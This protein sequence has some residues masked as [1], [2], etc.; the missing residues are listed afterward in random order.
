MEQDS[1]TGARRWF[2]RAIFPVS[3]GAVGAEIGY[4]LAA[5]FSL[6]GQLGTWAGVLG[7]SIAIGV[8]ILERRRRSQD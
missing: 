4:M 2:S 1:P 3:A 7:L 8:Q 6:H 5:V